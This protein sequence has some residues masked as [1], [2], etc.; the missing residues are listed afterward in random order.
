MAFDEINLPNGLIWRWVSALNF[1]QA[2]IWL[3]GK[4]ARQP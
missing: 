4:P 1:G 3:S 2:A